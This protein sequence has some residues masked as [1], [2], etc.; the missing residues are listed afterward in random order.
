MAIRFVSASRLTTHDSLPAAWLQ[1]QAAIGKYPSSWVRRSWTSK[2][3]E[4]EVPKQLK[5][6][7]LWT[8][9]CSGW[10]TAAPPFAMVWKAAGKDVRH[11]GLFQWN[12]NEH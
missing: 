4:N 8:A 6:Q 3:D 1:A 10:G 12:T 7:S 2:M 9:V 5:T 11:F